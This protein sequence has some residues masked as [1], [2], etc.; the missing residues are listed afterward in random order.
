MQEQQAPS[1]Q[2]INEIKPA[3]QALEAQVSNTLQS[4]LKLQTLMEEAKSR[5]KSI[6]DANSAI[7]QIM[8]SKNMIN[9]SPNDTLGPNK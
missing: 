8:L 6:E 4:E 9:T 1:E 5:F 7:L 3:F 2:F